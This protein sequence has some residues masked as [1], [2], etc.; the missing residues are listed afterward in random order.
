VRIDIVTLFPEMFAGPFDA[1]I[2]GRARAAGIVEIALHNPRDYTHDR[3]HVVDDTPFGGGPGMVMKP[4]P[5]F[6][7]VEAV[8]AQPGPPPY[9]VLLTP[10]GRLL[11]DALARELAEK[12]RLTVICGHY[13]GVDERV[14]EALAD[15]EISVGDYV[16]SGGEPAAIVLVDAV[17]RHVPGALGSHSSLAEES[18]A[19]GLLEYPQY[20]R[21]AEYRGMR[22]PEVLLSGDHARIAEWRRRER[23]LRTA[24]R[25]PD[26][27]ERANLTPAERRA[28]EEVLHGGHTTVRP[29]LFRVILP[30]AD[31]DQAAAFYA[32]LLGLDGERVGPGRQYFD[33]AGTVLACVDPRSEGM[34]MRPNTEHVCFAVEDVRAAYERARSAGAR[35]VDRVRRRPWGERS[36]YCR[37]P[38]DNPLCFVDEATVFTGGRAAAPSGEA[39]PGE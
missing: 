38:W 35:I 37:D 1:S 32:T 30:V 24:R 3:H 29:R 21:P 18:H 14:R 31:V 22:V 23:V 36:F 8:Q 25:R 11:T 39:A 28:V 12:P 9:V 16:L 7:C 34:E 15:D 17:V 26:M 4:E 5:L 6:E 27:L 2:I 33:C 13:E 19:E 10:Q 20:T